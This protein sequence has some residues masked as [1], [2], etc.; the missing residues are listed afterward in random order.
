MGALGNWIG[1]FLVGA[2][3][4][5]AAPAALAQDTGNSAV[6]TAGQAR[7]LAVGLVR[8]GRPAEGAALAQ[9]LLARDPQDAEAWIILARAA[10]LAGDAD[11][12]REAARNGNRVADTDSKR[13]AAS[14]ELAAAQFARERPLWAQFWLRR[15]AQVAPN[16]Q[17]RAVAIRSFRQVEARSPWAVRFEFS[18]IP[19]SNVNNG[20]RQDTIVIAGLPF[21]LSGDA[22]ALSGLEFAFGASAT[23]RFAGVGEKPAALT[24]GLSARRVRL[25]DDA[26]EQAPDAEAGDY[27]FDALEFGYNQVMSERDADLFW[28]IE[29][30]VG[31]NRYGGDPLSKYARIGTTVQWRTGERSLASLSPSVE[32]QLRDDVSE[33]SAW[34]TRLDGRHIWQ[35]EDGGYWALSAGVRNTSSAS[36]EIDH[37]AASV[38]LSYRQP[39]RIFGAATLEVGLSYERRDY[40]E[41]PYSADGRQDD[42]TRLVATV[43]FPEVNYYGFAPTLT[44]EGQVVE[45]NVSLYDTEDYG[46][47]LDFRSVF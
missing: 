17:L 47:R 25:S 40:A 3:V 30:L 1:I 16:D 20:S 5:A 21:T 31:L 15:A 38:G 41:S 34:I 2:A 43:G 9:A 7:Q 27:A 11:A 28:R 29:T 36:S 39:G 44:F 26:R 13:Y 37:R 8:Q 24:F 6:L 22:Q 12:A 33:R 4:F 18:V 46:V 32:R 35:L 14:M 42:R 23:Y 10:R 45:S 19:S